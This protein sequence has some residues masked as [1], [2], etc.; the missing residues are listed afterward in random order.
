MNTGRPGSSSCSEEISVPSVR[1]TAKRGAVSPMPVPTSAT[2]GASVD[3][4]AAVAAS[5]F[6]GGDS[7]VAVALD[8]GRT[9]DG[10]AAIDG[11]GAS[12][13]SDALAEV[14]CVAATKLA[15]SVAGPV[16]GD[17]VGLHANAAQIVT[18]TINISAIRLLVFIGSMGSANGAG[19]YPHQLGNW[20]SF[21]RCSFCSSASRL[22]GMT[23]GSACISW[24]YGTH[25]SARPI[26]CR[27]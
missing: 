20:M 13:G 9:S 2:A 18:A 3:S 15:L 26:T 24:K 17:S 16:G 5:C 14:S 22:A 19:G 11:C 27:W 25:S 8:A 4:A 6:G 7:M 23:L 1:W 12:V 21:R 10:A